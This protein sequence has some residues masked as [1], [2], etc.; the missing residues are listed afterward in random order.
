MPAT[1]I[2]TWGTPTAFETV[3]EQKYLPQKS[4]HAPVIVI[5]T[6]PTYAQV[7]VCFHDGPPKILLCCDNY[8]TWMNNLHPIVG[9]YKQVIQRALK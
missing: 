6:V 4:S 3:V 8:A 9:G 5:V 1:V 2:Q 7:S